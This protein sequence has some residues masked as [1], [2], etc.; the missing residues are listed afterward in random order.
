MQVSPALAPVR[1]TP[2]PMVCLAA[3]SASK[4]GDAECSGRRDPADPAVQ[5]G[6][7]S[8][9]RGLSRH[10]PYKAQSFDCIADF[11]RSPSD[12]VSSVVLAKAR[13]G[14]S[15]SLRQLA[16]SLSAAS[17]EKLHH[18][19]RRVN[20]SAT[21]RECP[22]E[23]DASFESVESE[24]CSALQSHV[25]LAAS[26]ALVGDAQA[27]RSDSVSSFDAQDASYAVEGQ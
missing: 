10:Y 18:S 8:K 15:P 20:S 2:P 14:R 11:F 21:I 16:S 19:F 13:C 17:L 27:R 6:R 5:R 4:A 26:G 1:P 22:Q 3:S 9:K 23:L 7:I 12:D 25:T 24:L